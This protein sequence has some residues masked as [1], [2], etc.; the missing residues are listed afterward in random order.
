MP[1]GSKGFSLL[2]IIT[3]EFGTG[4]QLGFGFTL[5]GVGGLLGLNRTMNLRGAGRRRAQR[6]RSTS[7]CSRRTSSR[8]RRGSSATCAAFFPPRGGTFLIGPMAKLGWGTP[9]LISLSLGIIIEIPGNIAIVGVLKVAIPDERLRADHASRSN[10]IG[11]IEFDKKRVLVLR[12]AVRIAHPLPHARRRDGRAGRPS[13]TTRTSSSASA[14]STRASAAAAAVPVAARHR[15]QHPEHAG[16]ARSASRATSPSPPTPCSSARGPRCS[17]ASTIASVEGHL[18]FDALFQFSPFY[19]II[20]ISASL[21]VKVFGV[22][23][24]S[25]PVSAAP[26]RALA[27]ARR[28]PRVASRF[29]SGTSTSTSRHTWGDTQDTR[30]PPIAVMPILVAELEKVENWRAQLPPTPTSSWCRL[31]TIDAGSGAGAAPGGLAADHA[32]RDPARS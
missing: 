17:S 13:A 32:A 16:R 20:E 1:D 25:V 6:R 18:A 14:G 22:G 19:F 2:V 24:F 21:S 4:I 29:S 12:R 9:T 15:D 27:V 3:A 23:L 7:S 11:A 5:I 8:T 28:G 31:R 10:F 30:L 26:W